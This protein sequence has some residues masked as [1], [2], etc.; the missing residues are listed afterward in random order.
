MEEHALGW[1]SSRG[2]G[3]GVA[4]VPILCHEGTEDSDSGL[5]RSGLNTSLAA[6]C[7]WPRPFPE[8]FCGP[9]PSLRS[10]QLPP[11]STMLTCGVGRMR[12]WP[13]APLWAESLAGEKYL[14]T[15]AAEPSRP[16]SRTLS[17]QGLRGNPKGM[18]ARSPG[19]F[20]V[21]QVLTWV[22]VLHVFL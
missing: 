3:W 10:W 18:A 8:H 5:R 9:V 15:V 19:F 16:L 2:R 1:S 14:C 20:G 6:L 12:R 21:S 13:Q 11:H 7:W 22:K 17:L 4:S